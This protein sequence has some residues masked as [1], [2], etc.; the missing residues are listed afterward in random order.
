MFCNFPQYFRTN[1]G[2]VPELCHS[3]FQTLPHLAY[4]SHSI[5]RCLRHCERSKDTQMKQCRLVKRGVQLRALGVLNWA[6]WFKEDRQCAYTVTRRRVHI[7]I[8]AVEKQK[9]LHILNACLYSCVSYPARKSHLFSFVLYYHLWPVW[10]YHFFP[11][12]L[13]NGTIFGKE[14]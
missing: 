13:I 1:T 8:F 6:L 11:H 10:L 12:Y 4:T 2:T 7:T 3:Q 5:V 14:Y 9:L